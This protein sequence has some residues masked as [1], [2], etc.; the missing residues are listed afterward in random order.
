MF[1]MNKA[2]FLNIAAFVIATSGCFNAFS[3]GIRYVH[4]KMARRTITPA[5]ILVIISL[6]FIYGSIAI[7]QLH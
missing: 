1:F 4:A 6:V 7:V 3:A 2:E 5:V